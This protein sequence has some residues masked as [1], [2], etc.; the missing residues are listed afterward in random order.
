MARDFDA[1]EVRRT[2]ALSLMKEGLNNGQIGRE[3]S[4]ANQRPR[5]GT[6]TLRQDDIAYK[7]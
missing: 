3:L 4:V 1:L 7:S 2:K 6:T 5:N